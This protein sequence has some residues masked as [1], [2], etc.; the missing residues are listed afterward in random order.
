M[1]VPAQRG[2]V[3]R[4]DVAICDKLLAAYGMAAIP[5]PVV[6]GRLAASARGPRVPHRPMSTKLGRL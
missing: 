2:S 6:G 5:F 1:V 3:E 4:C